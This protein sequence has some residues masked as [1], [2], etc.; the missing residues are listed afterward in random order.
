MSKR[1]FNSYNWEAMGSYPPTFKADLGKNFSEPESVETPPPDL[2]PEEQV[3]R[4][5]SALVA[6]EYSAIDGYNLTPTLRQINKIYS[7][8]EKYVKSTGGIIGNVMK[9]EAA[10]KAEW[11]K[12][13]TNAAAVDLTDFD[14]YEDES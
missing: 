7:E 13:V 5:L 14:P 1:R 4:V 3:A 11:H 6:R 2:T 10:I 12:H 9:C 8:L